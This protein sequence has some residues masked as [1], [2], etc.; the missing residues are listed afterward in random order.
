MR[1]R[2][3]KGMLK[4]REGGITEA[5]KK[6]GAGEKWRV[7]IMAV[8]AY[9]T[10]SACFCFL[11]MAG[12]TEKIVNLSLGLSRFPLPP[13]N[14]LPVQGATSLANCHMTALIRGLKAR[15]KPGRGWGNQTN[16]LRQL[17]WRC[18]SG[19]SPRGHWPSALHCPVGACWSILCGHSPSPINSPGPPAMAEV[20]VLGT[21]FPQP[22]PGPWNYSGHCERSLNIRQGRLQFTSWKQ[23]TL[24]AVT[25]WDKLQGGLMRVMGNLVLL[26]R[27]RWPEGVRWGQISSRSWTVTQHHCRWWQD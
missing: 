24:W 13:D 15:H 19:K 1:L 17:P 4:I 8:W 25:R 10:F 14:V 16:R 5:W 22:L 6:S 9:C 11:S 27:Q 26:L 2:F 20:K 3:R 12:R 7:L 23:V 21:S 18:L